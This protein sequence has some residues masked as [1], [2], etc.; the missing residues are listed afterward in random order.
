M[1]SVAGQPLVWQ[2]NAYLEPLHPQDL[3]YPKWQ[4][5]LQVALLFPTKSKVPGHQ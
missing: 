4:A 1:L 2:T 5:R 3:P